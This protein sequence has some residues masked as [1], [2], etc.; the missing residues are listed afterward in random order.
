MRSTLALTMEF[1]GRGG[2]S[3]GGPASVIYK[4]VLS[5]SGTQGQRR[6]PAAP[7]GV[8]QPTKLLVL[9]GV[10]ANRKPVSALLNKKNSLPHNV[11]SWGGQVQGADITDLLSGAEVTA[12]D[13]ECGSVAQNLPRIHKALNLIPNT[14]KLGHESSALK[15]ELMLRGCIHHPCL[16]HIL[17]QRD[18]TPRMPLPDVTPW[19]G[20]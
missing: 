13:W 8:T 4:A 20:I 2:R 18:N 3:G 16:S 7:T 19:P 17:F 11:R 10:I 5:V 6:G 9:P 1:C 12:L 14:E 15:D